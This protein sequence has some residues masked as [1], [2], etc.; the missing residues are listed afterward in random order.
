MFFK[1][2]VLKKF[3]SIHRNTTVF[4]SLFMFPCEYCKI[5]L[6][7]RTM[8]VAACVPTP[9][10]FLKSFLKLFIH[11]YYLFHYLNKTLYLIVLAILVIFLFFF[12]IRTK[13]ANLCSKSTI[14]QQLKYFLSHQIN[15]EERRLAAHM[16]NLNHVA[17]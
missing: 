14:E 3:R 9:C 13:Q 10:F 4:E 15:T 11:L 1:I 5:K 16:F 6:F 2:A 8:L 7:Y 12:C 17:P